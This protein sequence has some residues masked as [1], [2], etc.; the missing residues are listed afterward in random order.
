[1]LLGRARYRELMH[2]QSF[3]LLPEWAVRWKEILQEELGL[4]PTVAR[5]LMREN[6]AEL[7][8][9]D[10]GLVPVPREELAAFAAYTGL[11]WRVEPVSLDHLLALLLEAE[12]AA[13]VRQPLEE[14]S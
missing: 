8:Y 11:P 1:M 9:L 14:P 6:R 12:A 13:P 5:D 3:M 4:P 7:V 10:T 2:A